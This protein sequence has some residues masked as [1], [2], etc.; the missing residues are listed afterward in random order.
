VIEQ[1]SLID[2]IDFNIEETVGHVERGVEH[3]RGANEKASSPCAQKCM[4]ILIILIL[5]MACVIGFKMSKTN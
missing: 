1:G 4:V 2:R 3:L 5:G